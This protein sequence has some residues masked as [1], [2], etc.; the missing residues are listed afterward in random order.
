MSGMNPTTLNN[1]PSKRPAGYSTFESIPSTDFDYICYVWR[2]R[3]SHAPTLLPYGTSN[4]CLTTSIR[5]GSQPR[6]SGTSDGGFATVYGLKSATFP[7]T[8][9]S[10]RISRATNG[11]MTCIR[12]QVS[13]SCKNSLK[14]STAGTANDATETREPTRQR[15]ANTATTTREARS[16]SSR[17]ASNSTPSTS[18]SD[19][20]KDRTSRSIGLI[21]YSANIRLVL[22]LTSPP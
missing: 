17:K 15:T 21:S 2:N 7:V 5:L 1:P 12:S 14:R 11:M 13:E 16:R 9:N 22:T 4:G 8:T 19:S 20:R 6:N 10:P 18:E 3:S